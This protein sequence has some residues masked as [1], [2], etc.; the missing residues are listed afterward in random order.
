MGKH[1]KNRYDECYA[2]ILLEGVFGE[3]Y[4]DLSI[5]D[6][7]DLFSEKLQLGI[8][9][10]SIIPESLREAQ[11]NWVKAYNTNNN[12]IRKKSI[13]RMGQLGYEYTGGT[14]AWIRIN[15]DPMVDESVLSDIQ[16]AVS[17]KIKKMNSGQYR[18]FDNMDLYIKAMMSL[19][20][21]GVESIF[22]VL[23]AANEGNVYFRNIIVNIVEDNK[24]V[25]FDMTN[26]Q[27]EIRSFNDKQS[28]YSI[29][30]C[31]IMN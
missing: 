6:K 24:L 7:P 27:Y 3:L 14:Q 20:D 16:R 17:K 26:F 15:K 29:K 28:D 31:E 18:I 8:E 25:L 9:V 12:D 22:N 4:A 5:K 10:T 23:K 19:M 21:N 30:A 2:K 1:T 13:D 11:E